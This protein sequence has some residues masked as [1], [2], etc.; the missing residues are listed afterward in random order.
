[1][2]E[3]IRVRFAPSP[4]GRLHIGGA[5]TAI[6]NWAFAH[7]MGGTFILRI[8]DTDPERSTEENV[9]VILN[10]MKWLGLDWDEGPEVGGEAGPY[11]QMQRMGT[12]AEALERLKERGAVYPCFCTKE[13]LDA[14][15]KAAEDAG[16]AYEGYDGTCRDLDPAEAARRIE[17]GEPH[18]WRLKVPRDH[19]PIEFDDAVYGHTS[20]PADVMDDM[21]LVRT[22]GSPTYNFA[23]VC[24]DSNMGITHVIRGDDHLS[25]TPRQ[26]LIYEAL[27]LPIPTFAHLSMILGP[28]GKKLSKR[29]GATSVEEYRDRGFLPDAMVNFLALLGWS[30]DGETTIMSRETICTEFSLDRIT[31][32]DAIFDE[33]KLNWMN[34]Q[35]IQQA[36]AEAWTQAAEP[37]LVET[38]ALGRSVPEGANVVPTANPSDP[39]APQPEPVQ[40]TDAAREAAAAEVEGGLGYFER[41]YPLVAERLQRLDEIP[42]KLAFL[43]WGANCRLDEKSVK[44]VLL[45]DGARADEAIAAC[46]EVLSDEAN[47]WEAAVLEEKCRALAEPLDMKLKN[48]LQPLRVAVCGNMVSPPLFEAI[49]LMDR[50][51]VLARIDAVV[52]RVF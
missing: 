33:T 27:G 4:T 13:E 23:V 37:W 17:A 26:I 18:V 1:M 21:I 14:K 20:F 50:A 28:D 30:L 39:N 11:F 9:A 16:Q 3:N 35:Y 32:K 19:G 44:K 10:A 7:A 2:A 25:N 31:K 47:P 41:A 40:I 48:L 38:V 22:D 6:F 46:R 24:D 29:H 8:E 52:A 34:G 42:D 36:G 51:D 5:R 43:F 12:Y 15:R 49:E 45:K